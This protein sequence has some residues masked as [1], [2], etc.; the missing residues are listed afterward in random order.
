[1]NHPA[2]SAPDLERDAR[3]VGPAVI[4]CVFHLIAG[5]AVAFIAIGVLA[6]FGAFR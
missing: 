3:G 1:M 4:L 2:C 6:L 5:V